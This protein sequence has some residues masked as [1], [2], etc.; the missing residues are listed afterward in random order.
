[1]RR[2]GLVVSGITEPPAAKRS[3]S[4]SAPLAPSRASTVMSRLSALA[5]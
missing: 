5:T 1:M 3:T 4:T 2:S